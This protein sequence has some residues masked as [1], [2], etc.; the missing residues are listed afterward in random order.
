MQYVGNATLDDAGD[1]VAGVVLTAAPEEFDT[2]LAYAREE[3]E[4]PWVQVVGR[5]L[6]QHRDSDASWIGGF[7]PRDPSSLP[8]GSRAGSPVTL[9]VWDEQHPAEIAQHIEFKNGRLYVLHAANTGAA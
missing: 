5:F 2:F 7:I 9:S 6:G 8:E 4:E 3:I 1:E